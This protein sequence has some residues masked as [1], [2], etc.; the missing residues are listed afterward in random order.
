VSR[1]PSGLLFLRC[2]FRCRSWM[3][4]QPLLAAPAIASRNS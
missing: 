2:I 4:C 3:S 1:Y